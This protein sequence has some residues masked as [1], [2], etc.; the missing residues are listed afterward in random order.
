[1]ISKNNIT[2]AQELNFKISH[3]EL[4]LELLKINENIPN[5]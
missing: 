1:M 4:R 2:I 3:L 5:K